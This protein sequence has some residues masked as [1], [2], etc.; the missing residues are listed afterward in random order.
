MQ[1]DIFILCPKTGLFKKKKLA[2]SDFLL[3]WHND[4]E[5]TH[6]EDNHENVPPIF[7]L[8]TTQLQY[9]NIF[10]DA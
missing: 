2:I 3:T 4:S 6:R 7:A 8:R 5:N 9:A 10:N 1:T